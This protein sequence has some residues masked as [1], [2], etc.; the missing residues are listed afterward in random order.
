MANGS[1]FA[2]TVLVQ[3][4]TAVNTPQVVS[5]AIV[6]RPKAHIAVAPTPLIFVTVAPISG[7]FAPIPTQALTITNGG[8]PGS[9]LDY[10]VTKL[11]GN[12]PWLVAYTPVSG[13]IPGGLTQN[14]T[15]VVQPAQGTAPGV[16]QESLRISG[17]SD[18]FYVDVPVQLT[19]S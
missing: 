8:L 12:S 18:N 17:Y 9:N 19:V 4:P 5:L 1:P 15:V 13:S 7:P 6:V 3:D 2:A 11:T 16:Y 14:V 10:Q